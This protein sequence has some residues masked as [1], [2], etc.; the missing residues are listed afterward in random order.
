MNWV[1]RCKAG[2]WMVALCRDDPQGSRR[3]VSSRALLLQPLHQVEAVG[4]QRAVV[5]EGLGPGS[6]MPAWTQEAAHVVL[7]VLH[8]LRSRR[9]GRYAVEGT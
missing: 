8:L 4:A 9:S 5:G 1:S 3:D 7:G 2:L 6:R